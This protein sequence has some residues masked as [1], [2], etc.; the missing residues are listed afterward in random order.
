MKKLLG[1]LVII[2]FNLKAQIITILGPES[3]PINNVLVANMIM[4]ETVFTNKKGEA[5]LTIFQDHDELLQIVHQSY[6]TLVLP[7]NLLLA[8]G[9]IS[10]EKAANKINV[11]EIP[12][13]SKTKESNYELITQ[14]KSISK[15]NIQQQAPATSADMLA[16]TGQVQ[17]QKSQLG[18]GSPILRGFEANRVLLV[19]DGVRMNNAIYR[20]GHLQNAIS[21][22]PNLL[23]G[24]EVIFGPNSLIYGSDALGGVIHFKTRNP[25][26]KIDSSSVEKIDGAFKYQSAM[27]S[28]SANVTYQNGTKKFAYF[29]GVTQNTFNDLRMG[30][31]R[32]HG[33]ENFGKINNYTAQV[34]GTDSMFNN[35]NPNIVKHSG[36]NQTDLLWKGVYKQNE[37]TQLKMNVQLSNTS[38]VPRVDK[39]N[40]YNNDTLRYG[41]WDYGPQKRTLISIGSETE[42]RK[43]LFDYNNTIFAY[44][45]IEEDRISR[46][47]GSTIQENTNEDVQVYSFNSDF[48]KYLDTLKNNKI[49]YG[50]EALYNNVNSSAFAKDIVTDEKSFL[51]TRYPGGGAQLST[52][53]A[54]LALQKRLKKHLL[55]A[56]VRYSYTAINAQFD[57][58]AVVNLLD[59]K[60]TDLSTK[61]VTSSAGYVYHKGNY[62]FY[63]SVSSA[64]K[65]PNIDDFG[66]IFEKRGDLTIPNPTLK[67]ETSVNYEIGSNFLSKYFDFD[68][69]A[70]FTQV[71]NLMTKLP[72]SLNG[73][74]TITTNGS[75]LNLVSLQNSGTANIY[76][77]F[78]AV[79]VKL[80]NHFNWYTTTSFT[81]GYYSN[82]KDAVAHIPPIYGRSS[83]NYK[84]KKIKL[85][86]YTM[87]NAKKSI[88]DFNLLSD[89][90][91]EAV[92]NFGS[93]AWATINSS[94]FIYLTSK[95]RVQLALE[96]LLD[97]H[98]KT[99]ASGIS[100]PGRNFIG[101]VYFKF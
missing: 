23:E 89:N 5:D 27:N 18:G 30:A 95:L 2:G 76:G 70:Y 56:G 26:F 79:R 66:K 100:A 19:V 53:A 61:A 33:F 80:N 29:I 90:P 12:I 13:A 17:I 60:D 31:N 82:L 10:L 96:N 54:Y 15:E 6:Q 24:A 97:A 92:E 20:S 25:K 57:T 44:Q 37:Y 75:E 35:E 98:Y 34:N 73:N 40:E 11:V 39:L 63:S 86:V 48:I 84:L 43:K 94:A 52:M 81:K 62:K 51:T 87:F 77:A 64:F 67:P 22:D 16:N 14:T 42:K 69:V 74:Q 71:F 85:S 83:L 41:Q 47:F 101:S 46:E 7:K 21:V 78:A 88:N 59:L 93:P 28:T 32:F 72:T 36:Y 38:N 58:N 55:K 4:D 45:M 9:T 3:L 65:A 8:R 49:N 99:F 68:V 91:Q 1:L 50:V